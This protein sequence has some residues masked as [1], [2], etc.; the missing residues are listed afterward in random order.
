MRRTVL[1]RH[2]KLRGKLPKPPQYAKDNPE[3]AKMMH[4]HLAD[5]GETV[6]ELLPDHEGAITNRLRIAFFLRND[7][8]A[9]YGFKE[10]TPEEACHP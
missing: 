10:L 6:E 2:P 1:K 7:L 3:A 9:G 8:V 4:Y 5:L